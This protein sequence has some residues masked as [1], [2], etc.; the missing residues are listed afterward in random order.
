[1]IGV[2]AHSRAK[3]RLDERRFSRKNRRIL[4]ISSQSPKPRFFALCGF[5]AMTAAAC[6]QNS[7]ADQSAPESAG[8][9]QFRGP[10]GMGAGAAS[11]PPIT[12]SATENLVWKTELPGGG[13]SSPIV[14]GDHIYLTSYTGYLEPGQS[15]GDLNALTRHLICLRAADGEISWQKIRESQTAGRRANSRSRLCRQHARRRCGQDLRVFWEVRRLRLRPP[16]QPALGEKIDAGF[17][18][19]VRRS[20]CSIPRTFGAILG[21]R[22]DRFACIHAAGYG[23]GVLVQVDLECVQQAARCDEKS[24]QRMKGGLLPHVRNPKQTTS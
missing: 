1:M 16:G 2:C 3:I 6:F 17:S 12:W 10:G 7:G 9:P 20:V 14:F 15:G 24:F 22:E 13:S 11:D 21:R 8:W 5:I 19:A 18:Q 4:T 23:A